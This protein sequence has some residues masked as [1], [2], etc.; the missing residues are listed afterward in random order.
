MATTN[1]AAGLKA[2]A[3]PFGYPP[4]AVTVQNRRHY[5]PGYCLNELQLNEL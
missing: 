5:A 4:N 2:L 1:K 3:H